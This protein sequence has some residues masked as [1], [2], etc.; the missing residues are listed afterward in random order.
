MDYDQE[1]Q[2]WN[3]DD[4]ERW[5]N[6]FPLPADFRWTRTDR[7]KD[8][9][10]KILTPDTLVM[11]SHRGVSYGKWLRETP[12][13]PGLFE[14]VRD[15]IQALPEGANLPTPEELAARLIE[16]RDTQLPP[17]NLFR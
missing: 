5:L 8:T 1:Y 12:Y 4:V 14:M 3:D 6:D 16:L 13:F 10:E 2:P 15:I 11:P 17:D 7:T 9:K